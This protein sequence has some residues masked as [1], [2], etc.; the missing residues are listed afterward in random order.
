MRRPETVRGCADGRLGVVARREAAPPSPSPARAPTR[1]SRVAIRAPLGPDGRGR[2]GDVGAVRS[3]RD[4]GHRRLPSP[5]LR[6]GTEI[7]VSSS[8]SP[9]AVR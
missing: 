8:P 3:E 2:A 6:V 9:T 5:G 7:F 1:R 4:A